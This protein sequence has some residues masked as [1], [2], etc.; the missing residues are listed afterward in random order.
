MQR[1]GA[2]T[3]RAV[4]RPLTA[5]SLLALA[6]GPAPV[7]PLVIETTKGLSIRREVLRVPAP[8]PPPNP[9]TGDE[10]PP[11]LNAVQVV[12]Y[13]V[14]TG[15]DAPR[16]ARAIVVLLPGFLGGAG[17][18]D[19]LAR[20]IVRRSTADAPL[21]AWAVD[22]RANL[23]EDRAGIEAALS[24]RDA[25]RL[26]GYYF[27]GATVDGGTFGGFKK[28]GE[29]AFMSEWGLATT[30]ADVRAVLSLVPPAERRGRVV[31][32]GH[33]LGASLAAQYAAWDFDG[34]AG[35]DELAGLVLI[36]GV[37]GGEGA[38]LSITQAQYE[39]T[40]LQGGFMGS[41][42]SVRQVREADRFFAFPL[43]DASLFATSVG[44]ALRASWNP[45]LIERDVPRAR[46]LQSIFLV[47]RLPRFTNRA[48]FGLAFDAASCPLS[49]AAVN[50]GASEGGALAETP[51]LFGGGT[52]VK[53]SDPTATYRW[54]EYDEVD[55]KE[56]TSLSD[57]ALA[58]A[59]P[60]VDFAE[61]YFPTRLSVDVAVGASLTLGVDEWPVTAW[62]LKAMHGRALS[63]PVL[64][65][66]AGILGGDVTRYGALRALLP[67]VGAGRPRAAAPRDTAEGF[68]AH[69]HPGFSH[70]DPLA[71][72]D[73]PGSTAAG[74]YDAL[75]GFMTRNT[76]AGGVPV[77]ASP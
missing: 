60:G 33:S 16:P 21:E 56:A 72:T 58:W 22:R 32:A 68:E 36:D 17:S 13:R 71:A 76:P 61:W 59:R 30:M 47:E 38:P 57:F 77:P 50:A 62:G 41:S 65:E 3:A 37:T 10:T 44:T 45:E 63:M 12:R 4:L 8:A 28:Q 18:F 11:E 52:I 23:L 15:R 53:P 6:C 24:A 31:L 1:A 39:S 43:L 69:A 34:T 51:A 74:W 42:P 2:V 7:D 27:E 26:T 14:D 48:A 9:L 46:A 25:N 49:I 40:G 35:H 67:P 20:A 73:V 64:V 70:I 5:L 54:R 29:L 19:S 75:A 66:A 55:P